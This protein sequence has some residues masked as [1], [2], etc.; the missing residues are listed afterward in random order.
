MEK[1]G[2][3]FRGTLE[4]YIKDQLKESDNIFII[5][6]AKISGPDLSILRQSLKNSKAALFMTKNSIVKRAFKD[7][8]LEDLVK[9]IDG[10]TGLVFLK[11]DPVDASRILYKFSS[12]HEQ[13]KIEGG[14]LEDKLLDRKDIER[15]ACLPSKQV[16]RAQA[17]MA[18]NSLIAGLVGVLKQTLRKFV[19][20]LWQIEI[21]KSKV[22]ESP[23][24][25][26]NSPQ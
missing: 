1:I 23:E 5:K 14:L 18:L 24:S 19:Y 25:A 21:K 22:K 8:K 10:P 4:N 12:E 9:F 11:D 16:L 2:L 26:T 17:V 3:L 6:Y 13:L 15:L 7:S 20:C